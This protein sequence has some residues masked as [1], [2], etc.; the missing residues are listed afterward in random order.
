V[1]RNVRFFSS[2][3]AKGLGSLM[4]EILDLRSQSEGERWRLLDKD[5]LSVRQCGSP[6]IVALSQ[7]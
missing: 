3:L 6:E 4:E 7:L 2:R 5:A 1:I